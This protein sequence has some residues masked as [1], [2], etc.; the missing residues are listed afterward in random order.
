MIRFDVMGFPAPQ[1]SKRH[2]GGGRMIE[3][4]KKVKPWREDVRFAAMNTM[5]QASHAI[6]VPWSPLAG[7]LR[8]RVVFTLPKPKSA[9]KRA[10][11]YPSRK[12][13]LDKLLRSTFDAIGSA[14]LWG[15]DAQV[16]EVVGIKAFPNE[17]PEALSAP[18][19][20]IHVE[21]FE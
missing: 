9:P 2:V 5:G 4:S 17:H 12:P 1:G 11:T 13:D 21:A 15:D 8:I 7:P 14:G 19:A 20:R 18:G 10:R 3:S 16:V 6:G